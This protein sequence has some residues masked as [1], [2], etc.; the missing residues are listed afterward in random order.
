MGR[1]RKQEKGGALERRGWV[2]GKAA[3]GAGIYWF[4][5]TDLRARFRGGLCTHKWG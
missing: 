3:I 4:F 5:I 2:A 1:E